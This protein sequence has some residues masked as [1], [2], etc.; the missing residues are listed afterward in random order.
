VQERFAKLLSALDVFVEDVVTKVHDS[1][2]LRPNFLD[3]LKG[4]RDSFAQFLCKSEDMEVTEMILGLVSNSVGLEGVE[5]E[6][7]R[8]Q[9]QEKEQEQEQEQEIEMERYVDMAYQRDGEEIK[10]WAFCTLGGGGETPQFYPADRFKLYGRNALPFSQDLDI[11]INHYDP[12]WVGDRRLKNAYVVL[13]L[14]PELAKLCPRIPKATALSE[15]SNA[16]LQK[17]LALLD[18]DNSGSFEIPELIEVLKSAE[19]IDLTEAELD[20]LLL[21]SSNGGLPRSNSGKLIADPAQDMSVAVVKRRTTLSF[22]ELQAVLTR[23][24]Y[25]QQEAGRRFVLLSLAEAETIRCILHLRQGK[26]PV[27]GC[28][29]AMALR[30]VCANDIVLDAS[31]NFVAGSRY[32][33]SVAHNSFRFFNSDT[34]YKPGDINILLR[35]IPAEPLQRR[36]FFTAMVACRRRLAKR[37][38]QTPLA[39]LF[40]FEDQWSLLKQRAQAVRM[41]EAIRARGLL[42]HDAF[43]KFDWDHNGYLSMGELYGA[44]EWLKLPGLSPQDVVFFMKNAGAEKT[45]LSYNDFIGMLLPDATEGEDSAGALELL[46]NSPADASSVQQGAEAPRNKLTKEQSRVMPKCEDELRELLAQQVSTER[47]QEEAMQK[48]EARQA[49]VAHELLQSDNADSFAWMQSFHFSETKL[50]NPHTTRSAVMYDFAKGIE[51]TRRGAPLWIE[52]R[53]KWELAIE[54]GVK[55]Y[56]GWEDN[57]VVLRVPFRK[58]GSGMHLNQYSVSLYV[59]FRKA[60]GFGDFGLFSS[61]GWDQFSKPKENESVES[62]LAFVTDRGGLGALGSFGEKRYV[63]SGTWHTITVTVDT[64]A[65]CMKT[66]CDTELVATIQSGK[67]TR[68]GQFALRGRVALLFQNGGAHSIFHLRSAT[69]HSR[70]LSPGMIASEHAMHQQLHIRDAIQ[71]APPIHR[72]SL[73]AHHV[74]QPYASVDSLVA[75]LTKLHVEIDKQ[76]SA[77]WDL[78]Q[79]RDLLRLRSFLEDLAQDSALAETFWT[80][81]SAWSKVTTHA[82]QK[83]ETVSPFGESLLHAAAFAGHLDL[84]LRL[85]KQ[86][87]NVNRQGKFSSCSA[88]HS[89]AAAGE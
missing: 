38:E 67:I 14:I 74:R 72:A 36:F 47:K 35:E 70:V 13:E 40:T 29:A 89:A 66:Y 8:E 45:Q 53:G 15:G 9:E 2:P 52:G 82:D 88:L 46:E 24:K 32:Q 12:K 4:M 62:A 86:G 54:G 51:G 19:D 64:V 73:S 57:Y 41:R 28:D 1:A 49:R 75:A 18:V 61:Q 48:L 33:R 50:T 81:A 34:H 30:C 5:T 43:Q 20:E 44:L 21:E 6:Q 55:C 65:G 58:N 23:G 68:D 27:E 31:S 80:Y 85:V 7:C 83:N 10:T 17:A 26:A 71:R 3:V 76:T 25:R 87:A 39:K 11:S 63:M 59:K 77:L 56:K 84:V 69:V 16:R 78:I 42:L 22:E 60:D 37:W 79:A